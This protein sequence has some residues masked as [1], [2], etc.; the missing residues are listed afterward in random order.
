MSQENDAWT[1]TH[2]LALIYVA[3]AYG[4]DYELSDEELNTIT[5]VLQGWCD[6]C[7][8]EG[9]QEVVVE[10]MAVFTEDEP[11]REVVN[12]MQS[13]RQ[14]LSRDERCRALEEI[15]RIARADGVL[16]RSEKS[17]IATLAAV[18]EIRGAGQKKVGDTS[19]GED[20]QIAWTI[21]HDM[22][23]LYV[24]VAHSTD[25]DLSEGEIT[26]M[27]ERMLQWQPGYTDEDVR[28]LLREVL[29]YYS[30]GPKESELKRAV[31]NVSESLP[32]LQRLALLDDLVYIAEADGDF[33]A[34]ER[35][36]ILT[37]AEAWNLNVRLNGTAQA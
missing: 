8:R 16:L 21:L 19:T 3:L 5:S 31:H 35:D 29:Q 17:L 1:T 11:E 24:V 15:V 18:W 23:L 22:G 20:D 12:S 7:D 10:A 2:D 6:E 28:K 34:N 14:S 36:M 27:I 32:M 37:L 33:T 26:A 30:S 25:N 9:V 13:L 4:T